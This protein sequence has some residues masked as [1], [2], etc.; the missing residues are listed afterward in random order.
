MIGAHRVLR[1]VAPVEGWRIGET[2]EATDSEAEALVR[3]HP[4]RLV[5]HHRTAH[6]PA[7]GDPLQPSR[8]VAITRD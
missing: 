4:G 5:P 1:C 2:R 3:A 7:P 8:A 6:V